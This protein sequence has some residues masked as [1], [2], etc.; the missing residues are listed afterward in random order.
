MFSC[1]TTR[2]LPA[3]CV[4][5]QVHRSRYTSLD[6]S[7]AEQINGKLITN[8]LWWSNFVCL[9]TGDYFKWRQANSQKVN[10]NEKGNSKP[11]IPF[12]T[13][14]SYNARNKLMLNFFG[15]HSIA[16]SLMY[17]IIF[18]KFNYSIQ[19]F[20]FIKSKQATPFCTLCQT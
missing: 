9:H 18:Y 7:G 20:I 6:A 8:L 11:E 16:E 12:F 15:S 17:L 2:S 1:A 14:L 5:E 4:S 19:L 3:S 13:Y 10:P